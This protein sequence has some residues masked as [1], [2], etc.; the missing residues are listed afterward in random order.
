MLMGEFSLRSIES[1]RPLVEQTV[2]Q[3]LD[4][5]SAG[6]SPADLVQTFS[7]PLPSLVICHLLGVPYGDHEFFQ[8]Q[9]RALLD[10]SADENVV[11]TSVDVLQEYLDGLVERRRRE[12]ADDLISRLAGRV[13]AGE[14]AAEE[15]GALAWFLLLAG[16][17]TT[18]NMLGLGALT[19]LR[20]PDQAALVR[21]GDED[22]VRGIVEELLR[23]L[24]VTHF[25][26]R[27][28]ATEDLDVAGVR[29]RA[30]EG[31]ICAQDV[32]NR[33]P[34]RYDSPDEIIAARGANRHL[35]FGFGVH[36]CLGQPL[37]RLELQVAYPALLNR[38]PN[39]RVAV[40]D[41]EI[42]FRHEMNVYGVHALPVEF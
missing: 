19:L 10:N 7:L 22:A 11:R 32:A 15:A 36:Q 38:F 33:D 12:P 14:L 42:K 1:L 24:T 30:G 16:H 21:E 35:A 41:S 27:R 26:R 6:G 3:L 40:P 25:G 17:E 29:I 39:L 2:D 4:K 31:I 23:L 37:A 28:V 20:N 13:T 18:S 5:M 34:E 9:S 8:A